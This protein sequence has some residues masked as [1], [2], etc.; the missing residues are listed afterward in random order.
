ME[1]KRTLVLLANTTMKQVWLG[2]AAMKGATVYATTLRIEHKNGEVEIG[3]IISGSD[4][5]DAMRIRERVWCDEYDTSRCH[6][7]AGPIMM[8]ELEILK[9]RGPIRREREGS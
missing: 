4:G 1:P 2:E 3:L 7:L 5:H 6:P 9:A 8:Q